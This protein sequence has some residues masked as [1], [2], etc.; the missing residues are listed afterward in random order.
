MLSVTACDILIFTHPNTQ[1]DLQDM[2]YICFL[3]DNDL[4][5][6]LLCKLLSYTVHSI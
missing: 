5:L 4:F 1:L 2:F 3:L 6:I